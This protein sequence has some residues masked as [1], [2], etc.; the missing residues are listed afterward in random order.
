MTNTTQNLL[1]PFCV[2]LLLRNK[3]CTLRVSK[4]SKYNVKNDLKAFAVMLLDKDST[5]RDVVHQNSINWYFIPPRSTHLGG[6][7]EAA[8]KSAKYHLKLIL[9]NVNLT[10]EDLYNVLTQVE[11]TLKSRQLPSMSNDPNDLLSLTPGHILISELLAA[12][13]QDDAMTYRLQ[14]LFQHVWSRWSNEYLTTLHQRT[15]W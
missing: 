11:A 3:G 7:W 6:F 5:F 12:I 10:C 9:G 13:P 2:F 15:R 1:K 14:Q 4:W 8:V